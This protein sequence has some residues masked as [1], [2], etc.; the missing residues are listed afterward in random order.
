MKTIGKA[1]VAAAMTA[2]MAVSAQAAVING[3]FWQ[4]ESD[5]PI[6]DEQGVNN[7]LSH[8]LE[9]DSIIASGAPIAT[10]HSTG[11]DYPAG[12][13]G[14]ISSGTSLS[15]FLGGTTGDGGSIVGTDASDLLLSVFRFTGFV[16]LTAG[17]HTFDLGSDDGFRLTIGGTQVAIQ[18]TERGFGTTS[19]N[20][21]LGAGVQAFELIY[22]EDDGNTGIEFKI[23]GSVVT[24]VAA[25]VPLPAAGWMLI[26][27]VGGLAA[28][29]RC[30]A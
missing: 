22:F 11:I 25:P 23:D 8:I 1:L 16:D 3:E 13:T 17:A 30:A 27:G 28:L 2:G 14:S 29:R 15:N 19:V 24:G 26:A 6:L 9:A 12:A 5:N 21:D 18:A 4:V 20:A 10:F 7:H